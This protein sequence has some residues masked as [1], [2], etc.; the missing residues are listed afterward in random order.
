MDSDTKAAFR[1]LIDALETL[2]GAMWDVHDLRREESRLT[3]ARAVL[4][5]NPEGQVRTLLAAARALIDPDSV[6]LAEGPSD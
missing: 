6:P 5:S 4:A 3:H 2:T 1:A